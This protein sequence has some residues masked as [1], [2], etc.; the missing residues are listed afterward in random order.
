MGKASAIIYITVA[1]LLLLL[2]SLSPKTPQNHR[3][4][5]LKLR[6]TVSFSAGGG[7]DKHHKPV[8]FDP[9]VA[10]IERHREDKEWEKGY[11][12]HTHKEFVEA[13][14]AE[15]QPE[16]ED[17]MDAEDY[18]ND[19]ERFNVTNRLVLLFPRID[20]EPVD[21]YV[22]EGELTEWY[23]RQAQKDVMHRT[24]RDIE[25]HDKNHDGLVSF[26]EYDPPSWSR[27][28]GLFIYLFL[29][30]FRGIYD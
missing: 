20:V 13:P 18:L 17:F 3:H 16:W 2:L 26:S 21:G 25:L 15:S 23:L 6:P 19:D 27:N 12:E 28:L 30:D 7:G 10:D 9:I 29:A 8:S 5:R 1:L 24:E 4:R 11:F 22:S 14:G